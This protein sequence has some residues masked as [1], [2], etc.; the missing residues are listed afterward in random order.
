MCYFVWYLLEGSFP[1]SQILNLIESGIRKA[2]N[3]LTNILLFNAI[4]AFTLV[5]NILRCSKSSPYRTKSE[6]KSYHDSN[7]TK[8]VLLYPSSNNVSDIFTLLSMHNFLHAVFILTVSTIKSYNCY[9]NEF[10]AKNCAG[11]NIRRIKQSE[12][13]IF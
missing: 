3:P 2:S 7:F 13:A 6:I 1:E 9:L 8:Y 11:E 4:W 12:A 10:L 5:Y